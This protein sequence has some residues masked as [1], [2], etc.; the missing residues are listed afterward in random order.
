[1]GRYGGAEKL[2][3]SELHQG[4]EDGGEGGEGGEGGQGGEGGEGAGGQ[5]QLPAA[6]RHDGRDGI[7]EEA[8]GS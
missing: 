2:N 3:T 4:R 7:A 5:Q 1:M 8:G 6:G